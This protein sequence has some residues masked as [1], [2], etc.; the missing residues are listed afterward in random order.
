[1][2]SLLSSPANV[3][4]FTRET[5]LDHAID[6]Y[7]RKEAF[8]AFSNIFISSSDSQLSLILLPSMEKMLATFS[9]LNKAV[10]E[11]RT[12]AESVKCYFDSIMTIFKRVA[13]ERLRLVTEA[14]ER[15]EG[16]DLL[17]RFQ[18]ETQN[19]EITNICQNIIREFYEVAD[20]QP[21]ADIVNP[22]DSLNHPA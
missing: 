13:P 18:M 17:E 21:D 4:T 1:M 5:L 3:C 7:Q 22:G 16:L 10:L 19:E 9:S 15:A 8:K 6:I 11:L 2:E 20:M 14:F 12:D